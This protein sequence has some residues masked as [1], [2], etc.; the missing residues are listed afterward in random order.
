MKVLKYLRYI[1]IN[2]C[3]ITELISIETKSF[4]AEIR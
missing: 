1:I 2:G 4:V 3:L